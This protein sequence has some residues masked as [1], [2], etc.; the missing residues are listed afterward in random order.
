MDG[1]ASGGTT[2]SERFR[3]LVSHGWPLLALAL[4]VRVAQ[5]L[6]TPNWTAVADP[7]DYSRH[8]AANAHGHGM[9][10]A[11]LPQGGPS[12]IRPPAYPVFLGGVYAVTGDSQTAGRLAAALL[13]VVA[14]AL[15][16]LIADM[17]WG[18]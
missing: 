3:A 18:R 8:A 9:A 1:V 4:A 6:A 10:Q 14:V 11:L 7:G 13:G 2:L 15:I 5:I 17:L 16:G 12:A